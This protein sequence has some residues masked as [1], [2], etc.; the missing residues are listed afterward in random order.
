MI[1]NVTDLVA[2]QSV[3]TL[4]HINKYTYIIIPVQDCEELVGPDWLVPDGSYVNT[5]FCYLLVNKRKKCDDAYT[6]CSSLSGTTVDGNTVSARL[7]EIYQQPLSYWIWSKFIVL[8]FYE[9]KP[10]SMGIMC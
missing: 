1:I 5:P 8:S 2:L 10:Y 3:V 4:M 7:V 9:S 6:Y